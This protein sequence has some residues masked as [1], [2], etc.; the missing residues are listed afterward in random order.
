MI[1]ELHDFEEKAFFEYNHT[2]QISHKEKMEERVHSTSK[3]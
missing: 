2:M 1:Q 3:K